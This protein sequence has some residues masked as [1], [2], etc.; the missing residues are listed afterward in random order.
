MS[1][2][3]LSAL[4][5][6]A[7]LFV[8][9][10]AAPG[11]CT[12]ADLAVIPEPPTYRD[13]KL[14]I[15]GELCTRAPESLVFPLRVLFVVD[16]SE[17]MRVTDPADPVSGETRRERAVREAWQALLAQGAQDVR[18]GVLRFSAEAQSRTPVDRDGD[19]VTDSYFTVDQTVLSAA[20]A[21]LGQTD[22]TTNYVAALGEAYYELRTELVAADL[23]S[24]PLS[25]YVVVFVSDGLPDVD[26]DDAVANGTDEILASVDALYELASLFRVGDFSLHTVYLSSGQGPAL[27]RPAQEL[28]Q[29]M[30]DLG[31]GSYRS[32][33]GG[34][35]IDFIGGVDLSVIRRVFTLKSLTAV[36]LQTLLDGDQVAT[37]QARSVDLEGALDQAAIAAA[38]V[39]V[40]GDGH[41]SCGEPLTDSDGDGLSDLV[42]ALIGSDPLVGDTDDDGLGDRLEWELRGTHDPTDPGDAGCFVP[43]PCVMDDTGACACVLDADVDGLCDCDEDPDAPCAD[44]FGHDCVDL[45]LDGWCDCPDRDGDGF[46]DYEDRDGDALADCEEVYYGSASNGVDSDADGLPDPVEARTGTSPVDADALGDFDFDL[47][48]N[49]DEVRGATDPLCADAPF[50]SRQAYRYDVDD[51]GLDGDRTCYAFDVSNITLAPTLDNPDARP[52]ARGVHGAATNRILVFAGEVAFDDPQAYAG[53]RVA[54]VEARYW[55]PPEDFKDP[56]SGKIR[57]TEDDFVAAGSFDPTRDCRGPQ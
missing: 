22:R 9:G 32:V 30:A 16:A 35:E 5:A 42:E 45:D 50:R 57:L 53:F 17:S 40:D 41:L 21:A 28:L 29:Q 6:F 37:L 26:P 27:D 23:E 24:L 34:E 20:T 12:D 1:R 44:A 39:D 55:G 18:V 43:S 51:L 11:G 3:L 33:A 2:P 47:T 19:G 56:P 10:H 25:K 36:N 14:A 54:C 15:S 4:R 52:D 48:N 31:G 46:C 7:L 8:A 13:D 38:F 49:G